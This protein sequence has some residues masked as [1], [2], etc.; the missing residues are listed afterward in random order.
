MATRRIQFGGFSTRRGTRRTCPLDEIENLRTAFI[1]EQS[2][3]E[4]PPAWA[5]IT[6]DTE[7]EQHPLTMLAEDEVTKANLE[8]T[9]L[10]ILEQ[11]PPK[12]KEMDPT[13]SNLEQDT[14]PYVDVETNESS[15]VD[16]TTLLQPKEPVAELTSATGMKFLVSEAFLEVYNELLQENRPLRTRGLT[17]GV[18]SSTRMDEDRAR[19]HREHV[20]L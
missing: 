17:Q 13:G 7:G 6:G 4:L 12:T 20:R 10:G 9:R 5:N 14:T 8:A 3:A 19:Q 16:D 15:M 1:L 18:V 2:K 11:Q